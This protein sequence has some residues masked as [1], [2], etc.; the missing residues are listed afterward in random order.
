MIVSSRGLSDA[1][2]I[3]LNPKK[4][5]ELISVFRAIMGR[6][7]SPKRPLL[8]SEVLVVAVHERL[9]VDQGHQPDGDHDGQPQVGG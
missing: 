6:G 3:G 7:R 4:Q 2:N 1:G 9:R 5:N 8:I